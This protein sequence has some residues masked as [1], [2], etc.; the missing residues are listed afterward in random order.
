MLQHALVETPYDLII[1]RCHSRGQRLQTHKHTHRFSIKFIERDQ[2]SIA[3]Q[4]DSPTKAG[5][6]GGDRCGDKDS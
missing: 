4:I 2:L 3:K 1:S 6:A 5:Q